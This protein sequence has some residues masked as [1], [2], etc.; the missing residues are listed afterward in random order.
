MN[1]L[2][3]NEDGS[4]TF[5]KN[6]KQVNFKI[7]SYKLSEIDK[8]KANV[9]VDGNVY[10]NVK[11]EKRNLAKFEMDDTEMDRFQE[12]DAN[13]LIVSPTKVIITKSERQSD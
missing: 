13:N 3:I 4:N 5:L 12:N 2:I 6:G 8:G 10:E 9:D 11:V 7:L 1:K